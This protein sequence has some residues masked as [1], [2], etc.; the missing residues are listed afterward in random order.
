MSNPDWA[1]TRAAWNQKF[2]GREDSLDASWELAA[3]EEC[4]GDSL[5]FAGESGAAPH[6]K[7]ACAALAPPGQQWTSLDE[8]DR[9]MEAHGRITNKLYAID[10]SGIARPSHDGRPH[11]NFSPATPPPEPPKPSIAERRAAVGQLR[12]TNA[13]QRTEWAALFRDAGHWQFYE[14]GIKWREAGEALAAPHPPGAQ[15]AF[16]WSLYYFERYNKEWTTHLPASR[17]DTDGA[18]DMMEVHNLTDSL[19]GASS[20]PPLPDWAESLLAGDWRAAHSALGADTPAPE[21]QPLAAL[22][23]EACRTAGLSPE[24]GQ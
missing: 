20:G 24:A 8:N 16:A 4:W 12:Q 15:R 21:F 22:L 9:R 17:W 3:I 1:A 10:P 11:P 19:D 5:F 23:A 18:E 13:I 6:Y 2:D 14:L 7:T